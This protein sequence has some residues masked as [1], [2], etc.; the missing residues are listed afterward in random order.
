[1]LD[2]SSES[3]DDNDDMVQIKEV[4][5]KREASNSSC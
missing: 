1:M 3:S 5:I 2:S 4:E